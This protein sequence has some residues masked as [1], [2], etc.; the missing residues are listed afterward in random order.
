[1][2]PPELTETAHY[3]CPVCN[4]KTPRDL[5]VYIDHTNQHIVEEIKKDHPQ[6]V[7]GDGTC[8]PCMDYYETQ[9]SGEAG[10]VNIGPTGIR[11]RLYSGITL[12]V[13]SA[14]VSLW[15][16]FQHVSALWS[17]F[18]FLPL[19]LGITSVTEARMRTCSLLAEMG[20]RNMDSGNKKIMKDEIMSALK[21]RG[22]KIMSSSA[23]GAAALTAV[24]A[25]LATYV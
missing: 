10:S 19:W 21:R 2:E 6:W 17:V 22:R 15:M 7:S 3:Q 11:K 13:L 9:I 1:M 25:L 18:L 4:K 20:V 12:L 8:K 23:L 5:A 24:T 14:L 16:I